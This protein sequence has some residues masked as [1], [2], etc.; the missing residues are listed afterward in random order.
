MNPSVS[1]KSA[2]IF[3]CS[4]P[5]LPAV[6]SERGRSVVGLVDR[7]DE[8]PADEQNSHHE[9]EYDWCAQGYAANE[10]SDFTIGGCVFNANM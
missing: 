4:S 5:A 6:F 7:V 1:F 3:S 9:P 10:Q 8:C 2:M